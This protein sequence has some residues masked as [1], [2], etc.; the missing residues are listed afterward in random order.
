MSEI[1][2]TLVFWL[3]FQCSVTCGRGTKQRDIVCVYQNLT[4]IE[5]EHCSHLSRPRSQKACRAGACP[6]W[7]ANR[8]REVCIPR[9]LTPKYQLTLRLPASSW[10]FP[11]PSGPSYPRCPRD[12]FGSLCTLL[13]LCKL[14][15]N[16]TDKVYIA[17]Y[18]VHLICVS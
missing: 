8:W 17:F 1:Q 9:R 2:L 12:M 6:S 18:T 5:D 10:R 4:Q 3:F 11:S 13:F 7:K 14:E 15:L 16:I